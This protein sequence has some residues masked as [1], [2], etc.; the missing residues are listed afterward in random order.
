MLYSFCSLASCS[1][2]DLPNAG[3]IF[4]QAGNLYGT[5]FFGGSV[6]SGTVFELKPNT[7]GSWTENVLHSF[8]TGGG[9]GDGS[10][11][12]ADLIFDRDGNLYGTAGAGGSQGAGVVFELANGGSTFAIH[13]FTGHQDGGNPESHLILDGAGN[14]YGTTLAGGK[15]R[16][17][18]SCGVA[19]EL[20]PNI[21]K[22]DRERPLQLYIQTWR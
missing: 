11:P 20:K 21:L 4:D 17:G 3:L 2:G 1:D 5:T 18:C 6:D 12:S 15:T 22:L 8:C 9:C 13:D 16:G 14:L 10:H 19:F 7:N